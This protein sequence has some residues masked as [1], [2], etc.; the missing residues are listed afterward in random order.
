MLEMIIQGAV[1]SGSLIIAIGSQ[2]AFILKQGILKNND[3]R[4]M[5]L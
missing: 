5:K 3:P 2:N 4:L 1:V